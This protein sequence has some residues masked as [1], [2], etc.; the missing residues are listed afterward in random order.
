MFSR[1][2]SKLRDLLFTMHSSTSKAELLQE[3]DGYRGDVFIFVGN[4]AHLCDD[5]IIEVIEKSNE[6]I[7]AHAK[8]S[9]TRI[10]IGKPTTYGAREYHITKTLS[11]DYCINYVFLVAHMCKIESYNY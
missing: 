5:D 9:G 11:R 4:T 10:K 2:L 1:I 8:L 6:L 3:L 7:T